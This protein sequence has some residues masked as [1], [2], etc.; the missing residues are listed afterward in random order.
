MNGRLIAIFLSVSCISTQSSIA[1]PAE[2]QAT[3]EEMANQG[4]LYLRKK[5]Y[6]LAYQILDKAFKSPG[7]KQDFRTVYNRGLAAQNL[8]RLEIAYEMAASAARL[9]GKD[10]QRKEAAA[11]FLDGLNQLYGRLDVRPAKGETNRVGRIFVESQTGIINKKNGKSSRAS[12][13]DSEQPMCNCLKVFISHGRYTA[14][15]VPVQVR[16]NKPMT[17][18]VY[19]QIN[20]VA[21]PIK[22]SGVNGWWIAGVGAAAIIATSVGAYFLMPDD[23][24]TVDRINIT[25]STP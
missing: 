5:R 7:G 16:K 18:D 23:S 13:S 14:N 6:K 2:E 17:V 22:R 20:R 3:V 9:A 12:A 4:R 15:N 1:A 8:L 25:R 19:L 24:T 21:Q 10:K 11:E